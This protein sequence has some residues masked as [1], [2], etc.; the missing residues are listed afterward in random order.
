MKLQIQHQR[1]DFWKWVD[2]FSSPTEEQWQRT[3][4]FRKR[5]I[6]MNASSD[7][8]TCCKGK[9]IKTGG[10]NTRIDH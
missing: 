10:M 9:V 7:T 4:I 3:Q 1:N 6:I 8:K 2:Q 5:I